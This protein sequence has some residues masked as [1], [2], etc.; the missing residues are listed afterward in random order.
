MEVDKPT[1]VARTALVV[2]AVLVLSSCGMFGGDDNDPS[3]VT[4]VAT[5]TAAP[6]DSPT[7]I[8]QPASSSP[9]PSMASQ[10]PQPTPDEVPIAAVISIAEEGADRSLTVGGFVNG[11]SEDDGTCTF[12]VSKGSATR[13]LT[14]L[15]LDNRGTTACGSVTFPASQLST[16]TWT[17]RLDYSGSSGKFTSETTTVTIS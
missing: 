2:C 16:G 5:V 1:L 14:Q 6:S 12:V 9:T 17:I 8:E 7:P 11:F 3:V 10:E 4:P 15:G 13:T